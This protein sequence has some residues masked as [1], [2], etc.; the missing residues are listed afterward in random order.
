MK[1]YPNGVDGRIFLRKEL[2]IAS[3]EM[4]EDS[5]GLERRQ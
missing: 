2:S 1:R 5:E 3:A 4:G